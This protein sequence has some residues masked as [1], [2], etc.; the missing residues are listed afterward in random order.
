MKK[1]RYTWIAICL[2]LLLSACTAGQMGSTAGEPSQGHT[3]QEQYDLGVRYLSDGDYEGAILAFSAAI[4]IDPKR[5]PAYV[6][7]GDAYVKSGGTEGNLVA[8]KVDYEKAIDLDETDVDA[9]IGLAE[10]YIRSG[11]YE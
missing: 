8:A 2:M 4:E 6:G 7:R 9:Y 5:A 3:W 11:D 10:I 1:Y